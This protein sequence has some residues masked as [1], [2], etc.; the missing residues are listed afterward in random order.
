[1]S[2][3]TPTITLV[4]QL[5]RGQQLLR[6]SK[7]MEQNVGQKCQLIENVFVEGL[8]G[9]IGLPSAF[10]SQLDLYCDSYFPVIDKLGIPDEFIARL[11]SVV[12]DHPLLRFP[13]A[14]P[15]LSEVI[16]W[17]DNSIRRTW[18][19]KTVSK[20]IRELCNLSQNSL[21]YPAFIFKSLD[22]SRNGHRVITLL[23]ET[24]II[25]HG[26]TGLTSWQGA[27]FL[28]DWILSSFRDEL[29]VLNR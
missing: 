17:L 27:L 25:G 6:H 10:W 23:E 20:R 16:N 1:M 22:R 8:F 7:I 3:A 9:H 15:H 21:Q 2:L 5:A 19:H 24:E 29:K 28:T 13:V 18:P 11:E 14:Y 12:T 26:T 4:V